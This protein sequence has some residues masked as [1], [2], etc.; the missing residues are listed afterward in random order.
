MTTAWAFMIITFLRS[1]MVS[2]TTKL[3]R[4]RLPTSMSSRWVGMTPMVAPPAACAARATRPISPT[5]PAP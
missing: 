3:S 5:S 4:S 2:V 1:C